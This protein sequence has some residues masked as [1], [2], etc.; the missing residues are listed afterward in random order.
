M[1]YARPNGTGHYIW[2]DDSKNNV[3]FNTTKV[4]DEE[5]DIFLYKLFLTRPDEFKERILH[6]KALIFNWL[7]NEIDNEEVEYKQWL[8]EK[9]NNNKYIQTFN[10]LSE[11]DIKQLNDMIEGKEHTFVS[12]EE[13]LKDVEPIQW[14]DDVLSG[15]KKVTISHFSD[16]IKLTKEQIQASGKRLSYDDE[17]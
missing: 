16:D 9:E 12:M 10:E 13:A 17:I 14:S 5:I 11:E 2:H 7:S 15:K 3:V 4:S 6:G 1:S 8:L